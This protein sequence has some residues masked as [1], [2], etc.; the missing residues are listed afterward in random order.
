MEY[1]DESNKLRILWT[2]E[3]CENS[4]KKYWKAER[5]RWVEFRK[6]R[7]K[8]NHCRWICRT[9]FERMII[10][11]HGD[12]SLLE[13]EMACMGAYVITITAPPE[14]AMYLGSLHIA[15]TFAWN[16]GMF[17]QWN[18]P[19]GRVGN[20]DL[21]C[22]IPFTTRYP[23][24]RAFLTNSLSLPLYLYSVTNHVG[25]KSLEQILS[26]RFWPQ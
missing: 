22:T 9:E 19:I 5:A 14:P 17:G 7:L 3:P 13:D 20:S 24:N 15:G 23:L 12:V 2:V 21:P 11:S 1:T 26:S 18:L 6:G 8:K 25:T 4:S 10:W 16:H